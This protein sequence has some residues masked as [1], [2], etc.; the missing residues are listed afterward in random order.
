[1]SIDSIKELNEE[2]TTMNDKIYEFSI[3]QYLGH[4][5]KLINFIKENMHPY[6][7]QNDVLLDLF[8]G[9]S[10]VAY[11]FKN[12]N[13]VF[14]NDVSPFAYEIAKALIDNN[15]VK[16]YED[17][18]RVRNFYR[19]NKNK[20]KKIF[21][22]KFEKEK[23]FLQNNSIDELIKFYNNMSNYPHDFVNEA[24]N[25]RD[26]RKNNKLF[27]YILFSSYYSNN[28]FGIHQSLDI[29]SLKYA[30]DHGNFNEIEKGILHTCLFY[31]MNECSFSRDGHFAQVIDLEKS[32]KRLL[33]S[34]KKSV[35]NYFIKKL[36]DF[37]R[38]DFL[39]NKRMFSKN[40]NY[41]LS[42][43][44]KEAL[45]KDKINSEIDVVYADPPYTTNKYSRYYHLLNTLVLYDYPKI[46]KYNGGYTKG[47]YRANRY[48]SLFCSKVN[49]IKEIKNLFEI[50]KKNKKIIAF[51]YAYPADSN[52]QNT[53]RYSASINDILSAGFDIFGERNFEVNI[54]A[55]EHANQRNSN[56]KKVNEYLLIGKY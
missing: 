35:Y 49:A 52:T 44:Y 29:D 23:I 8:S 28:Y 33:N 46:T 6:M 55:Y 18:D 51:S 56:N 10:I 43:N 54:K 41:A 17:F 31:A 30:I 45:L 5:K 21:K 32:K 25:I 1:M 42:L 48:K 11:N 2:K 4:K 39:V 13:E 14:A 34:R 47:L 50:C 15:S 9:T 53:S 26:Y 22:E 24:M 7:A 40:K 16:K 37:C 19:K 12:T 38:S 36:D 20:L 27:P 3:L